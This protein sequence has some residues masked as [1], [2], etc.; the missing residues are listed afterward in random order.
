VCVYVVS[1]TPS[2]LLSRSG[3]HV[4]SLDMYVPRSTTTTEQ[5]A[6]LA[7]QIIIVFIYKEKTYSY[8]SVW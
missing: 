4:S 2:D 8:H 3:L 1:M 5:I 7:L 6:L